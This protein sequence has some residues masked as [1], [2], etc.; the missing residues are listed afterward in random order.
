MGLV[1]TQTKQDEVKMAGVPVLG[2]LPFPT[3]CTT[4]FHNHLHIDQ[5]LK[6]T[7]VSM[8]ELPESC[9]RWHP[10]WCN[11]AITGLSSNM[12]DTKMAE[13]ALNT[14]LESSGQTFPVF[15]PMRSALLA[16]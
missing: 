4:A 10:G 2:W 1:F 3:T 8:S 16:L 7:V 13:T 15:L 9:Q 14:F 5:E 12:A 6:P 11:K